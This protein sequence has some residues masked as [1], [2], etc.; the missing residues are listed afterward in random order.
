[1]LDFF[2]FT[3]FCGFL[4]CFVVFCTFFLGCSRDTGHRGTPNL[5]PGA[6][7]GNAEM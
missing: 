5:V 1:M 4:F 2:V 7:S 3:F 6:H